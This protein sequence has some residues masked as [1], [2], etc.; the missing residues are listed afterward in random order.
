MIGNA[1]TAIAAFRGVLLAQRAT[2]MRDLEGRIWERGSGMYE[3]LELQTG[4]EQQEPLACRISDAW[5][6]ARIVLLPS[7]QRWPASRRYRRLDQDDDVLL[8]SYDNT[9]DAS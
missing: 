4:R 7:P 5:A 8:T 6:V 2:R 1:V 3:E 9:C